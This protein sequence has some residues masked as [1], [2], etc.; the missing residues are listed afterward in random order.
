V[1]C[2]DHGAFLHH[3]MGHFQSFSKGS[4]SRMVFQPRSNVAAS[5]KRNIPRPQASTSLPTRAFRENQ[6][7]GSQLGGL[8]V[9]QP[10]EREAFVNTGRLPG[11]DPLDAHLDYFRIADHLGAGYRARS[12]MFLGYCCFAGA[13]LRR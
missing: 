1:V 7:R 8:G 12:A 9:L 10:D 3:C 5:G 2:I 11:T 6:Q 4:S 13:A